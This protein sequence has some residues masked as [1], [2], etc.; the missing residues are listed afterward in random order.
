VITSLPTPNWWQATLLGLASFRVYRLIARDTLTEPVRAAITYGDDEAVALADDPEEKL[1]VVGGDEQ[2]KTWRVY[3]STLIRCPWC[4]GFYVSVAW[5]LLWA[6]WPR[7]TLFAATPWAI[8]A[9]VALLAK[10]LDS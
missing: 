3:L 10:N 2:P 1:E 8:A 9:A 5:W 7:P 6:Q 4:L